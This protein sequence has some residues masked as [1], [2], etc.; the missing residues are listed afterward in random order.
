[1]YEYFDVMAAPEYSLTM[2]DPEPAP[3]KNVVFDNFYKEMAKLAQ[4]AYMDI[5]PLDGDWVHDGDWVPVELQELG[6]GGAIEV[7]TA[8]QRSNV[9][10][11][12]NQFEDD[13]TLV[14]QR[15]VEDGIEY[16]YS[17]GIYTGGYGSPGEA[18]VLLQRGLVNDETTLVIAFRGSDLD[19]GDVLD[20]PVHEKH[21]AKLKP[22][23]DELKSY[24]NEFDQ[25]YVTGHSLGGSMAQIFLKREFSGDIR[26]RAATFGSPG[27]DW[28]NTDTADA[29]IVNFAHTKDVV[30]VAG[31]VLPYNDELKSL[32]ENPYNQITA[33]L[34]L[35]DLGLIAK[36][37][38]KEGLNVLTAN[39]MESR[40][41]ALY[42]VSGQTIWIHS[43]VGNDEWYKNINSIAQHD[44]SEYIIS[45]SDANNLPQDL[46]NNT[47][48]LR[49]EISQLFDLQ[50][51]LR[52]LMMK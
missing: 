8:A 3:N 20:W 45:A 39:A 30:V 50:G 18:G 7:K 31:R 44:I 34:S 1:M 26:F 25:I 33:D 42:F 22:L 32:F 2:V 35:V 43:S 38:V 41:D 16:T 6:L 15:G 17:D 29:R 12:L 52:W 5:P 40:P 48:Q 37:V 47:T 49:E 13:G 9:Q 11:P 36:Y 21:Y 4:D 14:Y 19:D 23:I 46:S 27:T 28:N 51:S 24:V 10:G